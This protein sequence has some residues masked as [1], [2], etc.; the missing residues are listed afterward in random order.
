MRARSRRLHDVIPVGI[1]Y[2][3]DDV[4]CYEDTRQTGVLRTDDT[5]RHGFEHEL[6]KYSV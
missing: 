2:R 4:P 6:D 1:L 5:I 3:N